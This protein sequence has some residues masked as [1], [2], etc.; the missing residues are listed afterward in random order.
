MFLFDATVLLPI[1]LSILFITF[2]ASLGLWI[3]HRRDARKSADAQQM[4]HS[5]G[6]AYSEKDF[7]GLAPQLKAFDMFRHSRRRWGRKPQ[8]KNVLRGKVGNTEVF[9][10]DY[11]YIVSTGK[12]AK[13]VSQTI[14]FADD[15]KWA[16]PDFRL[17]PEQWWHKVLAK[18]GAAEDINFPE[19]PDFSKRFYLTS[20]L[21]ELARQKFSPELQKFLLG[22]PRIHLEG[23]NYY[24]IAYHPR[25][26]FQG[27]EAKAFFERCCQLT[28]LLQGE[29]KQELLDLVELK[30]MA[31]E[32]PIVTP[33]A[34][35]REM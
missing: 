2:F 28:A 25:K 19:N 1:F 17:R 30:E 12:S 32:T 6:L 15:K 20:K 18:L 33:Q 35:T 16:L 8:V 4:A 9:Q 23:S 27:E 24:L 7:F 11:T 31:L 3:K 13:R 5:L 26:V 21:E 10:F 22:G 34:Q 29:N 14:F